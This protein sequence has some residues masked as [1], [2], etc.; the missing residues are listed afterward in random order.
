MFSFAA[1][2]QHHSIGLGCRHNNIT[3]RFVSLFYVKA[4]LR[5]SANQAAGLIGPRSDGFL[6]YS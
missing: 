4:F 6:H 2:I 3:Q 5:I 1:I